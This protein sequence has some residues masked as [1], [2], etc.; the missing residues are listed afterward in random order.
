MSLKAQITTD[1]KSAIKAGNKDH[2]RVIRLI[3]AAI[4]QIEVD[5]RQELDENVILSL[6][7]KMIKQRRDSVKQFKKGNREDLASIELSEIEVLNNY[8][9]EQLTSDE[10]EMI[11]DEAIQSTGANGM[12]DMGKVI[13]QIKNKISGRADMSIVSSLTKEKLISY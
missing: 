8:L 3:L 9:P 13:A 2:L 12:R 6:L 5:T 11:I 7:A 4:K 1:M 10:L